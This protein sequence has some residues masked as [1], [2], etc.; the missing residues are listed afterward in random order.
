M[1]PGLDFFTSAHAPSLWAVFR[2][3]SA[4]RSHWSWGWS[5]RWQISMPTFLC[6]RHKK[7]FLCQLF[8]SLRHRQRFLCQLFYVWD[9]DKDVYANFLYL[10]DVWQIFLCQILLSAT[11][12]QTGPLHDTSLHSNYSSNA[13]LVF[14]NPKTA[15]EPFTKIHMYKRPCMYVMYVFT[16]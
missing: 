3:V 8:V 15:Y 14:I 12:K 5:S 4:S 2:A 6:L 13:R 7:R 11:D 9:I 16:T 10:C 1:I